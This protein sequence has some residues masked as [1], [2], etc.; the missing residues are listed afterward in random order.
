MNTRIKELRTHLGLSGEKFGQSLGL[1]KMAISNLE[2][3]RYNITEQT[4]LLI[5]LT[6]NVNEQW[7]REGVGNMF[8]DDFR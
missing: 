3:G 7:L 6:Y 5:C 8:N 4:I 2:K 1:T